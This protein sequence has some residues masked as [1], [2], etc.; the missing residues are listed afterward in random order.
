MTGT[1]LPVPYGSPNDDCCEG[2][3]GRDG[4]G[5]YS[6]C[7]A[8]FEAASAFVGR[9]DV[10]PAGDG[11]SLAMS[12]R[13]ALAAASAS[14]CRRTMP[15]CSCARRSSATLRFE[16]SSSRLLSSACERL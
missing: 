13:A 6:G 3:G 9:Y 5:A 1:V 16:R 10:P 7:G 15:S 2:G 4:C 14:C 12:R 11:V 8:L